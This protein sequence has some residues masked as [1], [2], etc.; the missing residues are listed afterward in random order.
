LTLEY[1]GEAFRRGA[2]LVVL[3][4]LII[5]GYVHDRDGLARTAQS[6]DGPAV[7]A[8]QALAEQCGGYIAGGFAERAEDGLFNT[9]VLVGPEGLVLHY[10]KLHLFDA[11]KT[12]FAPGNLGLPVADTPIG[13]C[14]LCVC[15]DLRFVEVA[16]L[17]ALRGAELVLVPTAWVMGFDRSA[18]DQ[19]GYCPQA[20][21]AA[22]QANLNQTFIACASQAG[23][24]GD[25]QF[26]GSSLIADPFGRTALGPLSGSECAVELQQI[27]LDE[28]ARAQTRG[29]L[30]NPRADRRTDV[31]G[32]WDGSSAL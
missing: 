14:G 17:L 20:R 5:Q 25:L 22:L 9:A 8:W 6:I 7:Q 28:V 27:D 26:L 11:E 12:I 21:G 16:R 31:Y 32:L 18:W 2:R 30:I 10:R 19:E 24:A 15:Y 29:P 3:P 1:A 13:R 4:E 23:A